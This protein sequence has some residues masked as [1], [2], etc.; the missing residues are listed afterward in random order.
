MRVCLPIYH[1]KKN[2]STIESSFDKLKPLQISFGTDFVKNI[3]H[4]SLIDTN[5]DL[6][7]TKPFVV[8]NQYCVLELEL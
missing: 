6:R 1:A 4:L 7:R 3:C 5:A 8:H 2:L